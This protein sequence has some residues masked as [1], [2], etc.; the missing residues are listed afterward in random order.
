M[1]TDSNAVDL[2]TQT[3][4]QKL[5]GRNG[6]GNGNYEIVLEVVRDVQ[7]ALT[8]QGHNLS[9]DKI[10]TI[11]LDEMV[12]T[13]RFQVGGTTSQVRTFRIM[14]ITLVII[15]IALWIIALAL[16]N[17]PDYIRFQMY[18]VVAIASIGLPYV[19]FGMNKL[20][21]SFRH[22]NISGR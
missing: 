6:T 16:G 2:A 12:K 18:F 7:A 19:I 5:V 4:R 14:Q 11:V 3:A 9:E 22:A 13:G 17:A 20:I 10:N 15:L 21:R 8:A 1:R